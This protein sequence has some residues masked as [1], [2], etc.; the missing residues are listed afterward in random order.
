MRTKPRA[1]RHRVVPAT[2]AMVA[3]LFSTAYAWQ[4]PPGTFLMLG[5]LDQRAALTVAELRALQIPTQ[6]LTVTFLAGQSPEQHTFV[7]PLLYDLVNHFGPQF[8]PEAK[9][10]RLRFHVSAT[11]SDEYQAIVAWGEF[12]PGFGNKPIMLAVSQDGQ[13]LDNDGPRLV[14]PGD[15]H[16]GRY[17]SNVVAL[18]LERAR[19]FPPCP[20][21]PWWFWL[22]SDC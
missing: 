9:N 1:Y 15:I 3:L 6:T 12:D 7:G 20:R 17:V 18:R 4:L 16:G 8:D 22:R 13:P 21:W 5:K 10:D 19:E 14:V 11:G 2:L